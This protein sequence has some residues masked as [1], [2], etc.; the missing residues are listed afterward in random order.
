MALGTD[1]ASRG[2]ALA[3]HVV[4]GTT[5]VAVTVR[6]AS[7]ATGAW[8]AFPIVQ[9]H[10]GTAATVAVEDLRHQKEEVVKSALLERRTNRGSALSLAQTFV[11]DVRMRNILSVGGRIGIEGDDPIASGLG[12]SLPVQTHLESPQS[13]VLQDDPVGSNGDRVFLEVNLHFGKLV[14]KRHQIAVDL[15]GRGNSGEMLVV[16]H[17]ITHHA[18][19]PLEP[20]EDLGQILHQ[21][22][23]GPLP[24]AAEGKLDLMLV[25]QD[26]LPSVAGHGGREPGRGTGGHVLMDE[27]GRTPCRLREAVHGILRFWRAMVCSRHKGGPAK[28]V[29]AG[30]AGP[31]ALEA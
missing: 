23:G 7:A 5:V 29:V 12:Q 25:P 19:L 24:A 16:R 14:L 27:H 8:L 15:R 4:A 9:F 21:S 1:S 22:P 30:L 10:V 17:G 3:E 11:L 31:F 20:V 13:D 6:S 26:R 28:S 18:D 2:A